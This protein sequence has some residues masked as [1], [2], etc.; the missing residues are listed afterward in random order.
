M[1]P[2]MAS[3]CRWRPRPCGASDTGMRV[4]T[5]RDIANPSADVA[6]GRKAIACAP[7]G[8]QVDDGEAPP[9]LLRSGRGLLQ[10]DGHGL[11]VGGEDAVPDLEPVDLDLR[12]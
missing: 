6:R 9:D 10:P 12:A 11:G 2:V 5:V 8:L 3:P 7:V 1:G 4:A